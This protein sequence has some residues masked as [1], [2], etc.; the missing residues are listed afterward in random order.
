MSKFQIEMRG[1]VAMLEVLFGCTMAHLATLTERPEAL[2]IS[3]MENTEQLLLGALADT[4][5]K[6]RPHVEVA[7]TA[8]RRMSGAM[9]G[10]INKIGT[11]EGNA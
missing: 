10:H 5:P 4:Q 2:I 6:D 7:I 9:L 8:F 11:P 1:R 3:I